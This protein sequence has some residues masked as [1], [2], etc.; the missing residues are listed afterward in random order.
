[1]YLWHKIRE[2]VA[3]VR[4]GVCKRVDVVEGVK[5]YACKNIVR[6]DIAEGVDLT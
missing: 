1:M 2:A 4:Q 3:L 6:I 5:V